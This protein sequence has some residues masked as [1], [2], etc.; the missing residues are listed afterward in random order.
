MPLTTR[1]RSEVA[2]RVEEAPHAADHA[3][4]QLEHVAHLGMHREVGV[5]LA[6]ALL[7][8]R[9]LAVAHPARVLLAERQ[10]TQRFGEQGELADTDRDLAGARLE[11]RPFD[12]DEIAEVEQREDLVGGGAEVVDLEVELDLPRRI[13]EVREGRLAVRA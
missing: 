2:A 10:R 4:A 7:R 12:P 5:A 9:Q 3:R 11:Q 13:G 8:V 6:V 1:A